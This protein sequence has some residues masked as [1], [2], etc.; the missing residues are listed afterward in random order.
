MDKY[1][2]KIQQIISKIIILTTSNI[3][4]MIKYAQVHYVN[5][6]HEKNYCK[7]NI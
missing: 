4:K 6:Q 2:K 7:G 1:P 5:L 3:V